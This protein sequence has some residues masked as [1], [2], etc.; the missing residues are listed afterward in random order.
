[1]KILIIRHGEPDYS[2]DSLTDKGWRE[3]R[4]LADRL[5]RMPIDDFY[6][7]PL[8]RARDTAKPTLER[9]GKTAQTLNW[10][11]EFRGK[12][13]DPKT[14][15]ESYAWDLMPQYWT[16]CPELYDREGWRQNSVYAHGNSLEV[17]DETCRGLDALLANYGYTRTHGY[18]I[19]EHNSRRTIALFCH[20]AVAMLMLSHLLG[21]SPVPLLHGVLLPTSSVTLLQTE[22][23]RPGQVVFRC[24]GI[25]DTSHLY[26]AGEPVSYMGLFHEFYGEDEGRGSK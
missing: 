20:F 17:Y 25:G 26:A 23:R 21:V 6:V 12:Y 15:E 4:L 11:E 10:L 24:F 14:G 3:A 8:G 13:M 2:V 7:S 19:T 16:R 9:L 22:E 5:C 1:M 18:Y